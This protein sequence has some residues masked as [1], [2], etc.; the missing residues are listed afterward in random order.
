M[1]AAA[2]NFHPRW[3]RQ[4]LLDHSALQDFHPEAQLAAVSEDGI[5][6]RERLR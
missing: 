3:R 1:A 5:G 6:A 2:L 4:L